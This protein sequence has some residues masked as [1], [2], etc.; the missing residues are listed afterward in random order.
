MT[1]TLV[2]DALAPFVAGN[3]ALI[4][5]RGASA[6]ASQRKVAMGALCQEGTQSAMLCER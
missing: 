4:G 2:N 1:R 6:G 3:D 5:E